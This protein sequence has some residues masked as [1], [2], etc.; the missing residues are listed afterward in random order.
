[1]TDYR[2]FL[3]KKVALAQAFGFEIDPAE[4]NSLL[5]PHQRDAVV[6]AVAGGRRGLFESFGLG[7]TVQQ[8]EIARLIQAR[9]GG[10]V[11][12]VLPLGVRHE[13]MRDGARLGVPFQFIRSHD[14]MRAGQEFYLTNYES[15]RLGKVEPAR[16]SVA[17]LDEAAVLRSFGSD[18]FQEFVPLFAGVPYRFVATATPDPNRHKELIHYSHF[19]GVLDSGQA[20]TRFFQRNS[21]KAGD[22]TLYPHKTQE[23]FLWLASWSLWLQRPS[24][25]GYSDDGYDLPPL[26]VLYH[27]VAVDH[28][29]AGADRDGQAKLFR[30][31]VLSA[32]DASREKR[33]TLGDRIAEV[34]RIVRELAD[35]E[36]V[37]VWVDL[38][39]EQ[40]AVERM[41][42]AE[43]ITFSSLYGSQDIDQRE[44]LLG[45]WLERRTQAFVSKP[46][47]YGAGVN[48]Q[49]C[50]VMV[51]AGVTFKFYEVAQAVH[52][53][54]RFL[55]REDCSVHIVHAESE[56]EI[57]SN[58]REKW[59]QHN[60][61]AAHMS[62]LIREHGLSHARMAGA[63]TRSI[64][65]ERQ[66]ARG[67]HWLAVNN[68]C[69]EEC[70]TMGD[71]SVDL[72]VT[73]IPFSN[74]YEYTPCYDEQTE[75]L[76]KRGW[77]SFGNVRSD[78][79]LATANR[80][81]L[82][83]EWQTP[84]EIIWRPY[85]GPMFHFAGRNSFDLLVTPD[86]KMVVDR[87]VGNRRTGRKTQQFDLVSASE[88]SER[89]VH[90]GWRMVAGL[91][92]ATR[93]R[94]PRYISIPQVRHR[95][96]PWSVR[97]ER[98][99][100]ADFMRLAG[101]YLSEGHC[102]DD[103]DPG[104]RGCIAIAQS[105]TKNPTFRQEIVD[106]LIRIGLTVNSRRMNVTA[107][108]V[109]V[110]EFLRS[111][112][113]AGSYRKRIPRWVKDLH[114]DLLCILRDTMMKGDGSADGMAYVSVSRQLRDDF[115]EVC[116]LTG[117]RAC[118]RGSVV[119]IGQTNKYPELRTAPR[120]VRYTGMI[121][122]ATVPNHTLVVR[123]NGKAIVSGNSYNDF[124][125][126]D[127]DEHFFA[128][129]DF[130]TPELLRILKPGRLACVHVKDRILFGS[131]TGFGTPT[132]NPFHAKCIM[133]YQHHGFAFMGMIT[134]VTDVV[135]ENN[136]TYRLGWSEQCKDGTKMG[137]GS[138]EYILLLRKL[139][140]DRSKA[141]AD[142]PVRK[143]KDDYSRARW[144]VDAHAF[145]RS[146]GN[147]L[148]RAEEL[149]ELG[150]DK[151]AKQYTEQST[152]EI[153]DH[154]AHVRLGEALERRGALP[155]TFM[156][157]APGSHDPDVWHDVARMRTLNGE[158]A[159]RA[160]ELHI[161]ALQLDIV[162]RLIRRYSNAGETVF[163]PFSG[164]AT[165]PYM[166]VKMGRRGHG[167]ELN[168]A[169]WRDG[170]RYLREAEV[171]RSAPSLFDCLEGPGQ[172]VA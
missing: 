72:I 121:G 165:V 90:R 99:E 96:M 77:L 114:P 145:W 136:Q 2:A 65:I 44:Q 33:A 87:R 56:R 70:R 8:I 146:S 45:D 34:R 28:S 141:Y 147:R 169:Y 53:I 142:E 106:L 134:V 128:Q 41:L 132:V 131:V 18:T 105:P 3:E 40:T 101:W 167:V 55:Q 86:H 23:F 36:Q 29:S 81:T 84:S 24:D 91:N 82:E 122:C 137:I 17:S 107:W 52:R 6:W 148:L 164:L 168:T 60:D 162:E 20:L 75:V 14:E 135:R 9:V 54:Y 95:I 125:H 130:L 92:R 59:A 109:S 63:L 64:G 13:F 117:W 129:M 104:R 27:E 161:C 68:D 43:G 78:D 159:R 108:N 97:I 7:K 25:L 22:L 66:E 21:E 143:S 11:L 140:T 61:Q 115:Q 1:M 151:L 123:R 171:E 157:I 58:L 93:G 88:I 38:N 31:A 172:E 94:R 110:A 158:Q 139:P 76:T 153:Y 57:V 51:F 100:V 116:L 149:A 166:A 111:Q 118:V 69:V 5:F 37:V 112:F 12:I 30:N 83:F 79:L 71:G 150:P 126:T 133:H 4:V 35:G 46:V 102:R 26:E 62:G 39:D 113:G 154:E 155:A 32:A 119:R 80:Q 144:Q 42:K 170:V 98:I 10:P 49:Q 138:P 50:H 152:R 103:T 47:M 16:F 85:S 120:Q 160:V 67:E 127:N 15:V 48:L 163:D 156:A 74:H 19:L 73:S 89:F 124:G